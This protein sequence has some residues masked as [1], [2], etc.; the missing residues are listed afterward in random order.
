MS[1]GKVGDWLK[2]N[3]SGGT[4]L[5]G[6]LLTGNL[7]SAVS[8]GIGLITGATGEDDPEKALESLKHNPDAMVKLKEL[9]VREEDSVRSHITEMKRLELEDDQASHEQTQNTI[10]QG[11]QSEYWFIRAQRPAMAWCGLGIS[12]TYLFV[13]NNPDL[14]LLSVFMSLPLSYFGLREIGK[15]VKEVQ[16]SKIYQGVSAIKSLRNLGK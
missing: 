5:V 13:S 10:R 9:Y 8:T 4:K 15:N 14:M 16:K 2:D 11:D 1:W 12:S 7:P 3:V 6:S